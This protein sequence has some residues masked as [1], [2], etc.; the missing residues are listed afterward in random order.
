LFVD[1]FLS[2]MLSPSLAY[3]RYHV[4]LI[5]AMRETRPQ[6]A[7]GDLRALQSEP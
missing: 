6:L 1:G 5:K 3:E 2:A 7:M 4:R